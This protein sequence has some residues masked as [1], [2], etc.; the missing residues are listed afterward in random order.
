VHQALS[1]KDGGEGY[2]AGSGVYHTGLPAGLNAHLKGVLC[3]SEKIGS[4]IRL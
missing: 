3:I 4:R 2:N 1:T